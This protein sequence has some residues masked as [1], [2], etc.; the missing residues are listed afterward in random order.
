MEK[1]LL[2]VNESGVLMKSDP[3]YIITITGLFAYQYSK[4]SLFEEQPFFRYKTLKI[5]S[6]K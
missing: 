5:K 4:P 6:N 3:N 1:S 2:Y